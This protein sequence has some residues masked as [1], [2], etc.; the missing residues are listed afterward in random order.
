MPE[1]VKVSL[2]LDTLHWFSHG[3]SGVVLESKYETWSGSQGIRKER[4]E[5]TFRALRYTMSS[6]GSILSPSFFAGWS[7]EEIQWD[8]SIG[9]EAKVGKV[10]EGIYAHIGGQMRKEGKAWQGDILSSTL[11]FLGDTCRLSLR[12]RILFADS[13]LHFS[14]FSLFCSGGEASIQ[15]FFGSARGSYKHRCEGF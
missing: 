4:G 7:E 5:G 11:R 10:D 8:I 9:D 13:R 12:P 14:P 15:G 6:L 3:L 1:N 2:R